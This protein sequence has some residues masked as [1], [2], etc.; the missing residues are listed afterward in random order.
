MGPPPPWWDPSE[1]LTAA[2]VCYLK[3]DYSVVSCV[4]RLH[5]CDSADDLRC[6][7]EPTPEYAIIS[8]Y[9][10]AVIFVYA[11]LIPA[12][13]YSLLLAQHNRLMKGHQTL[14]TSSLAML[15]RPYRKGMYH[16][17]FLEIARKLYIVGFAVFN[18][19]GSLR[20]LIVS[21]IV[22]IAILMVLVR[23]NPWRS[24]LA[25][26][27]SLIS[28]TATIFTL[29]V[30]IVL[31]T[32]AI[33][34]VLRENDVQS[35]LWKFLDF[36]QGTLSPLLFGS[37]L[38]VLA[39][40]GL[41]SLRQASLVQVMPRIVY[42]GGRLLKEDVKGE[43]AHLKDLDKRKTYHVFISHVWKSGQDAARAI[44]QLLKEVLPGVVVFLDVDDLADS[45]A[46][47]SYVNETH[48]VAV[49]VSAG[50]TSRGRSL[51]FM[52]FILLASRL[53]ASLPS[54]ERVL[55]WI[56]F[57]S[58]NCLRELLTAMLLEFERVRLA[59]GEDHANI[60][61]TRIR[62]V[63]E[64][65]NE[66]P[67]IALSNEQLQ[68]ELD[69]AGRVRPR[70][71]NSTFQAAKDQVLRWAKQG[72]LEH[73]KP[74]AP[75][76]LEWFSEHFDIKELKRQM[77]KARRL[78]KHAVR[79]HRIRAYQQ[80]SLLQLAE[81]I[82]K[83]PEEGLE[84]GSR[85]LE[86]PG[87]PLDAKIF[88]RAP[89][90][91]DGFHCYVSPHNAGAVEFA[92]D[93]LR[94][95][96]DSRT[97]LQIAYSPRHLRDWREQSMREWRDPW[98]EA[99]PEAL[100]PLANGSFIENVRSRIQGRT[101]YEGEPYPAPSVFLLYLDQRTW[102]SSRASQLEAEVKAV[103]EDKMPMLLLHEQA[104]EFHTF[105]VNFDH[106]FRATP[107]ALLDLGIYRDIAVA[108]HAGEFRQQSLHEA[109]LRLTDLLSKQSFPKRHETGRR[110]QPHIQSMYED[111]RGPGAVLDLHRMKALEDKTVQ[112]PDQTPKNQ[113]EMTLSPVL[114]EAVKRAEQ[115]ARLMH[116]N[117]SAKH[118]IKKDTKRT[119]WI[120][121]GAPSKQ[122]EEQEEQAVDMEVDLTNK[123]WLG[124]ALMKLAHPVKLP[125]GSLSGGFGEDVQ[126]GERYRRKV[127]ESQRCMLW[128]EVELST[129]AEVQSLRHKWHR[130]R[131]FDA[132]SV[133]GMM[134]ANFN[135]LQRR[136]ADAEVHVKLPQLDMKS[137]SELRELVPAGGGGAFSARMQSEMT[138]PQRVEH[139]SPLLLRLR[140]N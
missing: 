4:K 59:G 43:A 99:E 136:S 84:Q 46:L 68:S 5:E 37:S 85:F 132:H 105:T 121:L 1:I 70:S 35:S 69:E 103:L 50:C 100:F 55:V 140:E 45:G 131:T 56:D 109:A 47:E 74:F 139:F 117:N 130:K 26:Y 58:K 75:E 34:E 124:E 6:T 91:I 119:A 72:C 9:A 20:Q 89:P 64:N 63:L 71:H 66:K 110:E 62:L 90:T 19:P 24:E 33:V 133:I 129:V 80:V 53:L 107:Q 125:D 106:F 137:A 54:P 101:A 38:A 82:V 27:L 114:V 111:G 57:L 81:S 86:C 15:H 18:E 116:V 88:L 28:H 67:D 23:A 87:G 93:E 128:R 115:A 16:F 123:D 8:Q 3:V 79:W 96:C 29:L 2:E 77:A 104:Q 98:D 11:G 94:T 13:F 30:C 120:K 78:W 25:G 83:R 118:L 95:I 73:R 10:I 134:E 112:V 122:Q 135:L 31:R 126:E 108:L 60:D 21:I 12:F 49:F 36:Q 32:E 51:C 42:K 92:H 44:K 76:L 97:P 41:F 17:E 127:L 14:V 48:V 52:C 113:P 22:A 7:C 138:R 61:D 39:F 102:E 40:F 65:E